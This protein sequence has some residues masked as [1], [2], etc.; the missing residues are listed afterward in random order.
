MSGTEHH[1]HDSDAYKLLK[2]AL[3]GVVDNNHGALSRF[4]SSHQ[5]VRGALLA[6][7]KSAGDAVA[8]KGIHAHIYIDNR[9]FVVNAYV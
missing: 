1:L 7:F 9:F 8:L 3:Q 2:T 6:I 5:N 4:A